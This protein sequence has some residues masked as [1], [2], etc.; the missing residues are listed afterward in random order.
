MNNKKLKRVIASLV[1]IASVFSNVPTYAATQGQ[2][3]STNTTSVNES[4]ENVLKVK[5]DDDG[6]LTYSEPVGAT[7]SNTDLQNA[8]FSWDNASV[9]FV[10]TDRFKNGDTS[11]D[12]SY[13]RGLKA[14]GVTPQQGLEGSKNNANPGT[15]HG[16]DIK[17]LTQKLDDGYFTNLGVN[18][19]WITAP[20]E[21][22]HGY[23]SGNPKGNSAQIGDGGGFPYYGYHGYWALDFSNMDANMGTEQDFEKFV[24][25]AHSKGIRI[26]MDVVMNHVGY[27]TMKDAS[28]YGFGALKSGWQN[29]YYGDVDKISGGDVECNTWYDFSSSNWSSWWGKDFVRMST[30][31]PGYI[32]RAKGYGQQDPLCGL[33]DVITES[34]AEISTPPLL[35]N[36]WKKEGRYD[37]QQKELDDF[38]SKHNLPKTARNYEIKWLTDWVRKYGVDG[39]RC[40]TAKHVELASWKSL[41]EQADIA[42]KEWRQNNPNKPGAQWKDNFWMTGEVYDRGVTKGNDGYYDNG[43]DSLINFCFPKDCAAGSNLEGTYSDYSKQFN[44]NSASKYNALSYI[45]SHDRG[46]SGRG[47]LIDAGTALLLTP[48]A[49]QIFYGDETGRKV[50]ANWKAMFSYG[51]YTDQDSRSD[52]NWDSIDTAVL[53]H[54]QKI[55]QF[56]R[57]H[58]AVG[59][60]IHNQIS[61][62]PY[63]FSRIL[64]S[65]GITD[66][67]VCALGVKSA[68]DINVQGVFSDGAKVRDFYTGTM[69][70]VSGGKV[71]VTPDKNGVVLLEKGDK[72]PDVGV[73][74]ASKT[75][76]TDSLE[77]TLSVSN[78][79]NATY[80]IDGGQAKSF[81]NGDKITIGAGLD[82][83]TT[84]TVTVSASNSDGKAGPTTYTY[85]KGDPLKKRIKIHFKRTGWTN[86][87]VH[88]YTGEGSSAI[89]LTG[90]WPGKAMTDDGNGWYSYEYI[91]E[92]D[93][94]VV[95]NAAGKGQDP[96]GSTT[97]GYSVSGEVWYEEGLWV[98]KDPLT[99]SALV[100]SAASPQVNGT[101]IVLATSAT[102]GK[103][104][105]AYQYK[106]NGQ[107]VRDYSSSQQFTWTP[108]VNGVYTI[109]VT[110]KDQNGNTTDKTIL[111][112]IKNNPY[113]EKL[114]ID[115]V[116]TNVQSPQN[117]GS[118]IAFNAITSGG[119]GTKQIKYS[120][121][122]GQTWSLI[123]SYSTNGKATWKPTKPGTYTIN[124]TAKDDE[125]NTV[126]KPLTF[127]IKAGGINIE[128]FY[129]DVQSPQNVGTAI[130][131]NTVA[132]GGIGTIQTKYAV[133][134]G[135]KWSL[136]QGYSTIGKA[137]WKPTKPGT[138]TINTTAKD[139]T[140]NT[141]V[142]SL[143][144]V[145]KASTPITFS[146]ITTNIQSPQSLGSILNIKANA[147]SSYGKA[148]TY[149]FWIYDF[150][151]NWKLLKDSSSQNTAI[152]YPTE[153]GNYIIWVDVRDGLGNSANKFINFNIN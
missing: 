58:L 56:R 59:A 103:G 75:Y 147:T 38:F 145:V 36:K 134:D 79:A 121:F 110:V 25:T 12:H 96:V 105:L 128:S 8:P 111:Y 51:E 63:T 131:L 95:F 74:P 69:Y 87:N 34:T 23:T 146:S 18:A 130:T 7:S 86:P 73:S 93:A 152:W 64:A 47:N 60:G 138:Y 108:T 153:V 20:Y 106:I 85:V 9:Y 142:K 139:A 141:V 29:Y 41:K 46:L 27:I 5:I 126:V 83:D 107:V 104:D 78:D 45:S 62:S 143:T 44:N 53:S 39:Y 97:P 31:L 91:G 132:T 13:G 57:N 66:R 72:S 65:G 52:M 32:Y 90:I 19:I 4:D 101:S 112:E 26:V 42:L 82:F 140:G 16:G 67:V 118:S 100:P 144:Y 133:F 33:P 109:K 11:N 150:D 98:K 136:I 89:S 114:K 151:G 68:T 3:T 115:S 49:A 70:T 77:L 81:K 50:E 30:Q 119:K 21:Q 2:A 1:I 15:F 17:G 135:Q 125:G 71:S 129:A 149:K 99:V 55:G 84:T 37:Q 123:Q 102:G 92:T 22:M 137:V 61:T 113:T 24:D 43:F 28:E 54:W 35:V 6:K 122:D 94:K 80:S 88:V 127:I 10:L 124:T 40:D 120:V 148:L 116:T 48:G 117:V 76:Y 14:D